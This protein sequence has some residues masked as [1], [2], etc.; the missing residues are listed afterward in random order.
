MAYM[1]DL[2]NPYRNSSPYLFNHSIE[3]PV[4]FLIERICQKFPGKF[5][6]KYTILVLLLESYEGFLEQKLSINKQSL[7]L[8]LGR[9][10][11]LVH[12]AQAIYAQNIIISSLR[13]RGKWLI[14]CVL[15]LMKKQT[16]TSGTTG[17][18]LRIPAHHDNITA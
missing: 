2:R 5:C 10:C 1:R 17:N 4:P 14:H 7:L 6:A 3:K 11:V 16:R 18:G 13:S 9:K 8:F 15:M 12:I